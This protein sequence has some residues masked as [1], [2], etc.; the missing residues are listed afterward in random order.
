MR[1]SLKGDIVLEIKKQSIPYLKII[2]FL[3]IFSLMY[4][5]NFILPLEKSLLPFFDIDNR[6]WHWCEFLILGLA[7]F[8]IFKIKTLVFKDLSISV[9]LGLMVYFSQSNMGYGY[10]HIKYSHNCVLLLCLSDT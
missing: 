5:I 7:I 4:A 9:V 3:T 2:A 8:Y 1:I 6:A 10:I